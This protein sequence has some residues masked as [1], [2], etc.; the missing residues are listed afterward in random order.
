ME[1]LHSRTV[2]L[3][4][5]REKPTASER[6]SLA[7]DRA[8]IAKLEAKILALEAEI[9]LIQDRLDA[10]KYP[11]LT[12]PPEIIS[13][14]FVHFLPAYPKRAPLE[15][16]LSPLTLTQICQTWRAIASSTGEL[17]R[18]VELNL[19]PERFRLQLHLTELSLERS[20]S[21]ALTVYFRDDHYDDEEGHIKSLDL[22]AR[23][24]RRFEHLH[25]RTENLCNIH[26]HGPLPF[27]RSL[28]LQMWDSLHYFGNTLPPASLVAPLLRKV[29]L[30]EWNPHWRSI[31]P[32][33][34][35]TVL[36]VDEIGR[37]DALSLLNLTPNLV[38]CRL[39]IRPGNPNMPPRSAA[40]LHS[41][42][43]L[44]LRTYH[45]RRD[46]DPDPAGLAGFCSK[47]TLPALIQL[48]VSE[49]LLRPAPVETLK[50]LLLRSDCFLWRLRITDGD[51][52]VDRSAEDYRDILQAYHSRARERN[53]I[54]DGESDTEL[55]MQDIE[56]A[57][58]DLRWGGIEPSSLDVEKPTYWWRSE[59]W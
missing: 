17:W 48:Q 24:C 59:G 36:T 19:A 43:T 22:I 56:E 23:H 13:Q 38:F 53:M 4:G 27:L 39:S 32:W 40:T 25:L 42:K 33:S 47:L 18:G 54:D 2:E 5:R 14:T 10:Y 55:E 46:D 34:Q 1:T 44:L 7:A 29:A 8:R 16:K 50:Q 15:G 45:G 26:Q 28:T 41:L 35:L 51:E 3:F 9:D 11:V 37:T 58:S 21:R 49:G 57:E 6:A 30:R 52:P 31:L 12:I 20:G